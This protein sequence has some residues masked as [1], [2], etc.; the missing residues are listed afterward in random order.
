MSIDTIKIHDEITVTLDP[1]QIME[2]PP[3]SRWS[4]SH[5]GDALRESVDRLVDSVN[6]SILPRGMYQFTPQD[7]SGISKY[8]PPEILLQSSYVVPGVL[9]LGETPQ[10]PP[11]IESKFD[12]LV[13]DA[14]ENAAL[15]LAR[16]ELLDDIRNKTDQLEF[17]TTRVFAPGTR[18][19][20]WPLNRRKY[21]FEALPT[22]EIEV[23]LRDG[24]HIE[25][26]KTFT[27]VIG[28]GPEIEQA[29]MLISC[30]ECPIVEKC[31]YAG[32]AI[33]A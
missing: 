9:T 18:D 7:K 24:R 12:S 30:A 16:E 14:I 23:N 8:D 28:V 20:N 17:N 26:R 13:W 22:G 4:S 27:F 32:S 10:Q 19:D 3:F 25:P 5:S 33:M 21:M 2:R 6:T 31:V 1:D 29:E 11:A 15:Q